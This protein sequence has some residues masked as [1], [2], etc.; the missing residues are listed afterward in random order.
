MQSRPAQSGRTRERDEGLAGAQSGWPPRGKHRSVST[1]TRVA[2]S[3]TVDKL[4]AVHSTAPEGAYSG[5]AATQGI[6][7]Q[8]AKGALVALGETAEVEEAVI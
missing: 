4:R 7:G 8:L 6:G 2:R 5:L 3:I 1:Y